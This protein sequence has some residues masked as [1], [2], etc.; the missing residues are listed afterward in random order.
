[1]CGGFAASCGD[2]PRSLAAWNL[3]RL[4]GYAV[5]GAL[6][7]AAGD[8]LPGPPWLPAL[9][10]T[11]F[12]LWFALGLAGVV[13]EPSFVAPVLLRAWTRVAQ[14]P[15]VAARFAFGL[16]N[17]FLPCGLVYAALTVPVAL[18][19]PLAGALSR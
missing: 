19:R 7:G 15:G 1:M 18:A 2:R 6:A 10:A 12:L 16:A 8:L 17:G 5:L 9:V 14:S 11:L 3:G 4:T 13:A